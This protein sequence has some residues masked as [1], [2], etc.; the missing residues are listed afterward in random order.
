M[1]YE[2]RKPNI[3]SLCL[4]K[5]FLLHYPTMEDNMTSNYIGRREG[6]MRFNSF[7]FIVVVFILFLAYKI[8][9]TPLK[10][11]VFFILIKMDWKRGESMMLF[12]R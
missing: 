8:D 4:L 2:A 7:V 10:Q 11:R 9:F 3:Q 6:I 5:A 1:V 12:K